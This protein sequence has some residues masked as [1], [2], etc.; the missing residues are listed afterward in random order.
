M[1]ISDWSSDVCSSDLSVGFGGK[2]ASW[3]DKRGTE[4]RLSPILIGGYV[5]FP[6]DN[7]E[8]PK[9]GEIPLKSLPRWQRA[10][11]V[12]AGPMINLLL[13]A[14]IFAVI[15]SA[16]GSPAGRPIVP[17]VI[18]GSPAATAGLVPGTAITSF[19]G[20]PIIMAAAVRPTN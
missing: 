19:T 6:D 7:P 18:A 3:T 1:R 10:I 17:N 9:E 12:A 16:Y 5:K 14:F 13:A 15:A 11:V 20:R 8:G 2:I 4:W